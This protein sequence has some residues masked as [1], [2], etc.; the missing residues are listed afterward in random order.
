MRNLKEVYLSGNPL[1][2]RIPE[3]WENLGGI[4]GLGLSGMGLT[5]SIPPSMGLHLQ[6]VCYLSLEGNSLVGEIPEQLTL[7]EQ[8]AKEI[9]MENNVLRGRIPFSAGFVEAI[10]GKLKLAGNPN[11]CVSGDVA[12][13]LRG[14]GI[15]IYLPVCKKTHIPLHVPF[16]LSC[17]SVVK[18]AST[19]SV[20][21]LLVLWLMHV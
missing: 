1:G 19:S 12:I 21:F 9:N 17:S 15:L 6:N 10:G 2:G 18:A 13:H 20:L 4:L 14:K 7:L 5:G 3:I 8:S 11:L 16:S